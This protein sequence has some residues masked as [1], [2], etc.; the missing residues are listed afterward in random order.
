MLS[1]DGNL[2]DIASGFAFGA[3]SVLAIGCT[4]WLIF[5]DL[6]FSDADMRVFGN[7]LWS[8]LAMPSLWIAWGLGAAGALGFYLRRLKRVSMVA[9]TVPLLYLASFS[10][11]LFAYWCKP[12]W[13]LT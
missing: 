9:Q 8:H 11:V 5:T 7:G 3:T 12:M 4:S 1:S 10:I 13:R 2:G 6:V